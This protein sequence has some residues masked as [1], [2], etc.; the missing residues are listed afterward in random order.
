M[1]YFLAVLSFLG[2]YKT[3]RCLYRLSEARKLT[4]SLVRHI[5]YDTANHRAYV[6]SD[7]R[8]AMHLFL[9]SRGYFAIPLVVVVHLF[10]IRG[11]I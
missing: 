1:T 8:I 9:Q 4:N 2:I 11:E 3:V 6:L 7:C 5:S 10:D